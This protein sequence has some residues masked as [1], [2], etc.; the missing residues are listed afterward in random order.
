MLIFKYTKKGGVAY[1]SHLDLLRTFNRIFRRA[2]IRV[3]F[4]EGFHPHMRLFFGPPLSVGTES[5][6]EYCVADTEEAP[7]SFMEKFNACS[8]PDLQCL[9]C[10][11]LKTRINLAAMT[12]AASYEAEFSG[13]AVERVSDILS[14]QEFWIEYVS[15]GK[16][17]RKE[18]RKEIFALRAEGNRILM[19]LACG[20]LNLRADRLCAALVERYGGELQKLTR[21]DL[22]FGQKEE[23]HSFSVYIEGVSETVLP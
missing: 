3:A 22:L 4:S 6:G 5:V 8:M 2:E 1:L 15:K 18:V 7:E 19:T 11:A 21:T 23:L 12:S 9:S 16:P 20:E 17:E 13:C 14:E 10:S